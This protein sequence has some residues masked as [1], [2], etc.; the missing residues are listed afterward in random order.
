MRTPPSCFR[1]L[2]LA[3]G[4]AFGTAGAFVGSVG[5]GILLVASE[6]FAGP[7]GDPG[8]VLP[9]SLA[10]AVGLFAF[11]AVPAALVGSLSAVFL[12]KMQRHVRTV[13]LLPWVTGGCAALLTSALV[14][15]LMN[16]IWLRGVPGV[17]V[18]EV[19]PFIG[20][21]VVIGALMGKL[22]ARAMRL[23]ALTIEQ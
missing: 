13:A 21:V 16:Q 6:L 20:I 4:L 8:A 3:L 2:N 19:A 18:V 15:L 5:V 10:A 11:T 12:C 1:W 7:A 23:E 17:S 9:W 22:L 14:L